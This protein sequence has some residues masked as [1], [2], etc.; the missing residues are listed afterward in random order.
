[1]TRTSHNLGRRGESQAAEYLL[2]NNY[3]ILDRNYRFARGEIDIIAAK[4]GVLVFVEVKTAGSRLFGAP[5]TWVTEAK[6]K[7][8]GLVAG[9]F[10]QSRAIEDQDC[11]FD[12]IAIEMRDG[13][14]ELRHIQN[15]FWL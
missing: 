2:S 11:R 12:V 10:L 5:E 6:Q 4:D 13:G 1:M 15:A 9:H 7:Q 14:S 8:I 3:E